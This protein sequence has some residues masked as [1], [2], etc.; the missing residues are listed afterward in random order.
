MQPLSL[1]G[2]F[3]KK[4]FTDFF[5]TQ[6]LLDLDKHFVDMQMFQSDKLHFFLSTRSKGMSDGAEGG[7]L[8]TQAEQFNLFN[9]NSLLI[10]P[11]ATDWIGL[12]KEC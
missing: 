2:D 5:Y 4:V 6:F 7:P 1:W 9:C 3:L 10:D 8:R 12:C 11:G